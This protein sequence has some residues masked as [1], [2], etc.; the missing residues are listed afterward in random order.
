MMTSLCPLGSRNRLTNPPK[1][2][3]ILEQILYEAP[4]DLGHFDK[5]FFAESLWI[6]A[7]YL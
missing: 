3:G 5:N 7:S 2:Y 6:S 4:D 1:V